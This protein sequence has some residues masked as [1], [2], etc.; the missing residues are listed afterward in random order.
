VCFL[1]VAAYV[2][3]WVEMEM[4]ILS[5]FRIWD[6]LVRICIRMAQRDFN[7]FEGRDGDGDGNQNT[8][9]TD[10]ILSIG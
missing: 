7:S 2:P 6:L 9:A 4:D 10:T 5:D 8:N 3:Y 1:S